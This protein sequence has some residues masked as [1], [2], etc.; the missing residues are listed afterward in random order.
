[1]VMGKES[2]WKNVKQANGFHNHQIKSKAKG[3]L[4]G[5]I[6]PYAV[7]VFIP[8]QNMTGKN[9]INTAEDAEH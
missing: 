6:A 8:N 2:Q 4:F 3:I 5:G 1:M 9:T 7:N